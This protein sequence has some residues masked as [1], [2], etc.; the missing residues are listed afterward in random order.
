MVCANNHEARGRLLLLDEQVTCKNFQ[1]P[2]KKRPKVRQPKNKNI[3]FIPLTQ[4]KVAIVDAEDYEWLSKYKWHAS[5][6]GGKFYATR[7]RKNRSISMHRIIM[8]EPKGMFVDHID[9]NSQ[10]NRRSN[11]RTCTPAQNLQ[12]QRP[13]EGTSRYK[14][15]Y[16]HKKDNKWMAKIGFNGKSIYIGNF[17]D[18][19]EAAKAYDTKATELFGEFAYLNFPNQTEKC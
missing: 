16:F 10:N 15:V 1:N 12:N 6:A 8:G 4:G 18:E 2:E 19:I 11:L 13:K 7:C 14:G 5:N 9:G 17:E 3:R